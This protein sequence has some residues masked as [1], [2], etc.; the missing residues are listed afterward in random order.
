METLGTLRHGGSAVRKLGARNL[1][2]TVWFHVR[3]RAQASEAGSL[4]LARLGVLVG[5]TATSLF[6]APSGNSSEEPSEAA[7]REQ[8]RSGGTEQSPRYQPRVP[9]NDPSPEG[10]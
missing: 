2:S 7:E 1:Q 6:P 9:S 3:K 5:L 8:L 4:L 10:S